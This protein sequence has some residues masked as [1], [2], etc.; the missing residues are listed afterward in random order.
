M[1]NG[2]FNSINIFIYPCTYMNMQEHESSYESMPW[3]YRGKI[4]VLKS[5]EHWGGGG[6]GGRGGISAPKKGKVFAYKKKNWTKFIMRLSV[7]THNH[8]LSTW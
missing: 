3:T 2:D 6:G 4:L 1:F 5:L 7:R 8:V